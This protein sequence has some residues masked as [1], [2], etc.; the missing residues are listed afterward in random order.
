MRCVPFRSGAVALLLAVLV[1]P[2]GCQEPPPGDLR[3]ASRN[4]DY[5]GPPDTV[6]ARL[7]GWEMPLGSLQ[8]ERLD[9]TETAWLEAWDYA[10]VDWRIDSTATYYYRRQ[11]DR[12]P[13]WDQ[14]TVM[15]ER[16]YVRDDAPL[17]QAGRATGKSDSWSIVVGAM[18]DST[19][20]QSL[21][22][23]YQ[24]RFASTSLSVRVRPVAADDTTLY[25][26]LVGTFDSLAVRRALRQYA[27][28]LPAEAWPVRRPKAPNS[29]RPMDGSPPR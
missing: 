23:R 27:P 13:R 7:L 25:R 28:K 17:K 19:S 5:F 8:F 20:A 14:N 16:L 6:K 11:A 24:V 12:R 2:T 10:L 9:S 1:L 15:T 4:A 22:N 26:V 18:S 3:A 21:R 29:S